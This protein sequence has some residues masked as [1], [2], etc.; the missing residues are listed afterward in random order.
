MPNGRVTTNEEVMLNKA[1]EYISK[2]GPATAQDMARSMN[3]SHI[4]RNGV[5]S[6]ELASRMKGAGDFVTVGVT[7]DN[8]YGGDVTLWGLVCN[9]KR[10]HP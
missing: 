3:E 4:L 5:M 8:S 10:P 7:R 1:R 2:H 6:R 9:L